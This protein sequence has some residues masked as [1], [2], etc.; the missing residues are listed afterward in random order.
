M[1]QPGCPD[2]RDV[3]KPQQ[4]PDAI[5][6]FDVCGFVELEREPVA[7][8]LMRVAVPKDHVG[9]VTLFWQWLASPVGPITGPV[10]HLQLGPGVRVLWA[11]ALED[12]PIAEL[13]KELRRIVGPRPEDLPSARLPPF[14]SFSELRHPWGTAA[15][16]K[17]FVPE[18][19][20]LSLWVQTTAPAGELRQAGARLGGYT[21]LGRS[22]HTYENLVRGM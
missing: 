13:P 14:G 6:S 18:R 8:E 10:D 15:P 12:K 21:Q 9:V 16:V 1:A 22:Q 4:A 2:L 3:A 19:S 11:L 5:R 7:H 20:T 17:V